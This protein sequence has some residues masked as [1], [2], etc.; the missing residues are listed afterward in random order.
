MFLELEDPAFRVSN[1]IGVLVYL[2]E[3]S[4]RYPLSSLNPPFLASFLSL[5]YPVSGPLLLE[6]KLKM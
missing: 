6:I 5:K 3:W 2:E 4:L 1:C